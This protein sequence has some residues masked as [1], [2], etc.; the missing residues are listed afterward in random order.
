MTDAKDDKA[1]EAL[2]DADLD[3]AQG[4]GAIIT[5][6]EDPA[7]QTFHGS[8]FNDSKGVAAMG[9]SGHR[10]FHGSDFNA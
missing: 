1:P 2:A 8:D 6:V 7:Q 4:A 9:N 5:R 3:T 10:R